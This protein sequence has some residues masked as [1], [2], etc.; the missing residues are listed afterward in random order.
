MDGH[1]IEALGL[2][3]HAEDQGIRAVSALRHRQSTLGQSRL[4]DSTTL[5]VSELVRGRCCLA[6][7]VVGDVRITAPADDDIVRPERAAMSGPSRHDLEHSRRGR[8][9]ADGI[10]SPALNRAIGSQATCVLPLGRNRRECSRGR[11][12]LAQCISA[13]ADHGPVHSEPTRMLA[14]G[15]DRGE[16]AGRGVT[17]PEEVV[18]PTDGGSIC[19]DR[20][21]VALTRGNHEEDPSRRRDLDRSMPA[22]TDNGSVELKPTSVIPSGGNRR[23]QGHWRPRLALGVAP[24]AHDGTIGV[25]CARVSTARRDRDKGAVGRAIEYL[26]EGTPASQYPVATHTTGVQVSGGDGEKGRLPTRGEATDL[27]F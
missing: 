5:R 1:A 11:R 8:R 7:F 4:A 25:D 12:R 20:A 3:D 2:A 24:P 27:P 23:E 6:H 15:G 21:T 9:L 14:A 16:G 22:P 10:A 17:L 19:L 18:P 26:L 13:P